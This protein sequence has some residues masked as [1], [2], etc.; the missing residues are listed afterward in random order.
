MNDT[1]VTIVG[2]VVA[3]PNHV[4]TS[5]GIHLA[6]LRVA[7]TSR[8]F[9][10]A[11]GGWRDASTIYVTVS[12]WRSMAENVVA[13]LRKGDPV[14]A[15]G[16]LRIRNYEKDGQRRLSVQIEA[17]AIGH[18]LSRGVSQFQRAQP[19]VTAEEQVV[20]DIAGQWE[21]SEDPSD[22][23]AEGTSEEDNSE[24]REAV[25]HSIVPQAA[26]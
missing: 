19:V 26:A 17:S 10:R 20:D 5:S 8:R 9:D 21:L 15:A 3:E 16:R 18:D 12:C 24:Q 4:V 22:A 2:N 1:Y 11:L 13:S 25:V 14:V 7:S 6:T 23:T